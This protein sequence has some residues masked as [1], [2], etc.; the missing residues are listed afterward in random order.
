[1]GLRILRV[2]QSMNPAAGGPVE[3]VNQLTTICCREGHS[4]EVVCLD[5][6]ASTFLA[7]YSFPVHAI[8]EGRGG[9]GYC[10]NLIPWIRENVSRFDAV[11]IHG[12]WDYNAFGTWRA[13]RGTGVPYFVYPHGMLDPWF[14]RT[15]PLKHIKKWLYY[16]W[17]LYPVLRD[18]RAVFFTC[19]EERRV[20]SQSFWLYSC[21]EQ[22]VRYGTAGIPSS[23]DGAREAF[24][25]AHPE[26]SSKRI[27]L[28]L[29][30]VHV[31]KGPDLLLKAIGELQRRGRWD[32]ASMRVVFAGPTDG[33][34]A[35]ELQQLAREQEVSSS[36][37]WT[38][39]VQGR[40]KWGAFQAADAFVL[41]SHQE[42]F[43]IAVAEALS[44]GTPVLLGKGVNIWS[45]IVETGAGLAEADTLEGTIALLGRW[46][47]LPQ[48][49]RD[50]M[51]SKCVPCFASHFSG[52]VAAE[53]FISA[54]KKWMR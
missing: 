20:S 11:V 38:G 54:V 41:P 15:Y 49:D 18:A 14:K 12:V 43:G 22:V 23:M 40:L 28:F 37:Y 34:Y 21:N 26:L 5:S 29:G 39:L 9:Y 2:I 30:R 51:R 42:N 17:G 53:S 27:F 8:G 24:L 45:E 10:S 6:P 31:K 52:A 1:M 7:K 44:A 48:S 3:G 19:E 50:L 47:D 25:V 13:L 4:I 32:S 36:V 46:I 35:A 33:D 16:P